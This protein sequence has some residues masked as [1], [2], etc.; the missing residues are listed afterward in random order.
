VSVSKGDGTWIMMVEADA[1]YVYTLR[2]SS[3]SMGALVLIR[4]ELFN[5]LCV[6]ECMPV[7]VERGSGLPVCLLDR[8]CC[9]ALIGY[10]VF[11]CISLGSSS[12]F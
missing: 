6:A 9:Q 10:A 11:P 1:L 8:R 7:P 5:G 3:G 12:I 4:D 2:G